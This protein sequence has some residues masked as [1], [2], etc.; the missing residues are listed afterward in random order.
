MPDRQQLALAGEQHF[1]M[2]DAARVVARCGSAAP[3]AP[4]RSSARGFAAAVP[5][6]LSFFSARCISTISASGKY[7]AACPAN[8]IMRIAPSEKFGTIIAPT[9]ILRRARQP[10]AIAPRSSRWRRRRD[11]RRARCLHRDF[12]PNRLGGEIENDVGGLENS[13]SSEATIALAGSALRA[14][15]PA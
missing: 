13:S 11:A 6:G 9:S 3:P 12:E 10:F 5:E 2:R 4:S 8:R 14:N 15:P 7:R 1:L